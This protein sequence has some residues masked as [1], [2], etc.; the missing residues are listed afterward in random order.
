LESFVLVPGLNC[1]RALFE[2]QVAALGS[3]RDILVADHSRDDTIAAIAGRLL[4]EAPARFALAGLSMG[5]YIA[6]EAMRQAPERVRGSRFSTPTRGRTPLSAA[7]F[8][9]GRSRSRGAGASR[10]WRRTSGGNPFTR[11]ASATR[12]CAKPTVAWPKRPGLTYSSASSGP[13]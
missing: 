9:R 11:A 12:R 7:S 2:P 13:S 1:T 3:G 8:G 6:L 4:G 5:G 10:K